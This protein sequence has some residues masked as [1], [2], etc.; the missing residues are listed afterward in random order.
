VSSK[1]PHFV[2]PLHGKHRH[3]PRQSH[4][5]QTWTQNAGAIHEGCPSR[6]EAKSP[7]TSQSCLSN[8]S[9]RDE[10][11]HCASLVVGSGSHIRRIPRDRRPHSAPS[12]AYGRPDAQENQ[13][14]HANWM[15]QQPS[16]A[17]HRSVISWRGKDRQRCASADPLSA[18]APPGADTA[19]ADDV[20]PDTSEMHS[21]ASSKS[22]RQ[23][24]S[25]SP[26]IL[27]DRSYED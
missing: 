18:P 12:P 22:M 11:D 23:V 8:S 5:R 1:H 13:I 21:G 14:S 17:G 27:E 4:L 3:P 16:T 15:Q 24:R 19:E 7:Q 10:H 9:L 20:I 26:P 25:C 6:P 2:R